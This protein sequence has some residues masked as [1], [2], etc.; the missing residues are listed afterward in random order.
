[1][2]WGAG[3]LLGLVGT[4]EGCLS[5]VGPGFRRNNGFRTFH[6]IFSN[7][8][9][10]LFMP[11]AASGAK[12]RVRSTVSDGHVVSVIIVTLVPTLLFNVC[13]MNCRRFARAKNRN[14]FLR[15]FT[16]KFLTMLPGVVMSCMINLNVRFI[17]T[18]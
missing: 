10:F 12:A 18:R 7:F 5:G 2:G 13:G 6:S 4:L 3:G 15:V 8:R 9:A 17:V 1:M 16:C 11:D 14:D